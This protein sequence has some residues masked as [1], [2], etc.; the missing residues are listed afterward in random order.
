MRQQERKRRMRR[1]DWRT[2]LSLRERREARAEF[3]EIKHWAR[4]RARRKPKPK[5]RAP[6]NYTKPVDLS[7]YVNAYKTIIQL[8]AKIKI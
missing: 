1:R 8:V 6:T 2:V 4:C 7:N 3:N 5:T